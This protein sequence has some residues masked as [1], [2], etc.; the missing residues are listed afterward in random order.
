MT[1]IRKIEGFVFTA[2]LLAFPLS[3]RVS[4]WGMVLLC[5]IVMIHAAYARMNRRNDA[6][7]QADSVE[8]RISKAIFR[9]LAAYVIW[10]GVSLL[11]TH[12]I[13]YGI[14]EVVGKCSLL[15]AVIIGLWSDLDFKNSKW[16]YWTMLIFAVELS[17]LGIIEWCFVILSG[18]GAHSF[19]WMHHTYMALYI[20]V[21]MTYACY[22]ILHKDRMWLWCG[23]ALLMGA[24]LIGINSK[25]GLLSMGVI[26]MVYVVAS[27]WKKYY[28]Q[29][30]LFVALGMLTIGGT[31][32]AYPMVHNHKDKLSAMIVDDGTNNSQLDIWNNSGESI[33]KAN[34]IIGV[35][36]GDY[37]D[38][39]IDGYLKNGQ[40]D[41]A[42]RRYNSHNTYLDTTLATGLVG[43]VLLVLCFIGTIVLCLYKHDWWLALMIIVVMLS[44]ILESVLERQMGCLFVG[45]LILAGSGTK[46]KKQVAYDCR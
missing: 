39:L 45:W 13:E 41:N 5:L 4:M 8:K 26:T 34:P 25:V 37:M 7:G 1:M 42:T 30:C 43:L 2:I 22:Q 18:G 29:T 3:W 20:M 35:G 28:L 31:Y 27:L 38:Y 46:C 15:M 12:N 17:T 33:R 9:V 44:M 10:Y 19:H 36:A 6:M 14:T 23:L 16:W 40:H 21:G 24:F 32:A 11:W